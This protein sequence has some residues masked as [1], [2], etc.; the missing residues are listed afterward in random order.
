MSE[1]C[2]IIKP[3]S[4]IKLSLVSYGLLFHAV[5]LELESSSTLL[6]DHWIKR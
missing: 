4:A 3:F 2:R 6:H 1:V 5:D